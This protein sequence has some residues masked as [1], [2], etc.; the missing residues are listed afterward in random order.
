MPLQSQTP[1]YPGENLS[2]TSTN[3]LQNFASLAF[4]TPATPH[5]QNHILPQKSTPEPP[6][7]TVHGSA[8]GPMKLPTPLF[9]LIPLM[10]KRAALRM[11]ARLAHQ[12]PRQQELAHPQSHP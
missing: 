10:P 3:Y 2:D 12:V 5:F 8:Q 11:P 4:P 9:H 7:Q 6:E 1:S